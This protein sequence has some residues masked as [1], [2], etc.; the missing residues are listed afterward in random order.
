MGRPRTSSNPGDHRNSKRERTD[1]AQRRYDAHAMCPLIRLY[2]AARTTP[3][4][5][6]DLI[7]RRL[8]I[9]LAKYPWGPVSCDGWIYRWVS[10]EQSISRLRAVGRS[11]AKPVIVPDSLA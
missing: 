2:E 10:E 5:Y 9:A 4:S 3:G 7:E 6:R 8:E 1:E 11:R